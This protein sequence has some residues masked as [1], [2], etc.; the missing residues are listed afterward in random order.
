MTKNFIHLLILPLLSGCG[1]TLEQKQQVSQ[2]ATATEGVSSTTIE[3]FKSTRDKIVELERRV[4]I[5]RNK[6]KKKK[7]EKKLNTLD[8]DGGM[9]VSGLA[10]RISTL[11]AL[12][13][14]GA[15]LNAL[16][17]DSQADAITNAMSDFLTQL[18]SAGK[19]K[20]PNLTL[21][22]DKKSSFAGIVGMA[23]S[24]SLEKEK[25]K[26]LKNIVKI[27]TPE[28]SNLSTY[29]KDDVVLTESSPCIKKDKRPSTRLIKKGVIDHYCISVQKALSLSKTKL[30]N[31][32]LR[33]N[34]RSFSYDTYVLARSALDE[35]K[36]M[37]KQGKKSIERLI[38]ANES[39]STVINDDK[40]KKDDIKAFAE[41]IKELKNLVQILA[42]N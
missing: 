30:L 40:I 8:L 31:G 21:D 14:Y 24:W 6:I 17:S 10:I 33:F 28:I 27:Y 39:L 3:Q 42:A 20:N 41:Q 25:K 38:K 15:L 2:F 37:S 1:L 12:G 32:G 9:N 5:M 4:L 34:E 35:I 13:E 29:L 7:L 11:K 36:L 19:R 22:A 16:A 18:E 23:A 26:Q